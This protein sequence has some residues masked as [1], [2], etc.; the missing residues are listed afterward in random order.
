MDRSAMKEKMEGLKYDKPPRFKFE[1]EGDFV[2]GKVIKEMELV[3]GQN[4]ESWE[5]ALGEVGHNKKDEEEME[6]CRVPCGT[7]LKKRM[8]EED[9]RLGDRIGVKY[10][11]EVTGDSRTYKDFLLY[12]FEKASRPEKNSPIDGVTDGPD[13]M[14]DP[15]F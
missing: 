8:E 15:P 11:G 7:V 13:A 6:S 2:F 14:D 1:N 3:S 12:V 10:K 4:W 9:I 5:V